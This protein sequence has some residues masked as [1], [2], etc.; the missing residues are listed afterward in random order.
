MERLLKQRAEGEEFE[1]CHSLSFPSY[2]A[3]DHLRLS[4]LYPIVKEDRARLEAAGFE[5]E[6]VKVRAKRDHSGK[7]YDPETGPGL[8][9]R[10][11][12]GCRVYTYRDR[13]AVIGNPSRVM[14]MTNDRLHEVS[15]RDAFAATEVLRALL[16]WTTL[17]A[18]FVG[19]EWAV[20][21]IALAIDVL[22]DASVYA[23]VYELSRWKHT[24]K[25]P[26]RFPR[27]LAWEGSL[28]RLTTYD[29]GWEMM[30]RGVEN[31]PAPGTVMRVERQIRG[32]RAISR[33]AKAIAHGR[34]PVSFPILRTRPDGGPVAL[35]T[36]FENRV[37]HEALARDLADLDAPLPRGQG[38]TAAVAL[39]ME[40]CA[41]FHDLI[42]LL[43][44]RKTYA[45]YRRRVLDL[46]LGKGRIPTLLQL[47]YGV[48][49]GLRRAGE[50]LPLEKG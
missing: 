12:D 13:T 35:S 47:C 32:A 21:E 45:T 40:E 29:K 22:A 37:L 38:L 2:G 7:A 23:D 1:S 34:G 46:R 48:D 43:P 27:G 26:R 3:T 50:G 39:H 16:P 9:V 6:R 41:R 15:E 10:S 4:L 19:V 8:L 5:P 20:V 28:N 11:S 44:D 42:R 17:K 33:F 49:G 31:A 14:G 30:R 24:S 18:S 25:L 36:P